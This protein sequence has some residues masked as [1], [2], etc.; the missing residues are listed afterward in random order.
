MLIALATPA[1]A[2]VRG[3]AALATACGGAGQFGSDNRDCVESAVTPAQATSTT[4][5]DCGGGM[6]TGGGRACSELDVAL[7]T[8]ACGGGFS[9]SGGRACAEPAETLSAA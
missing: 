6:S 1:A 9:G 3:D 4:I 2:T 8:S 5:Q 7:A